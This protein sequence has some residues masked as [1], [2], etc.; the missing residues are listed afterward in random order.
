MTTEYYRWTECAWK[1]PDKDWQKADTLVAGID[2][3]S[4]SS[5]AVI[6]ADEEIYSLSEPAMAE[7]IYPCQIRR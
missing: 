6:L 2:V 3:G 4:V 1:N 7:L 5:Q